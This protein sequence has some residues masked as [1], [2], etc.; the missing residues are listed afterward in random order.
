MLIN[1]SSLH[2]ETS[3]VAGWECILPEWPDIHINHERQK[4]LLNFFQYYANMDKLKNHVLC[5][6][7][8]TLIK[9]KKFFRIF[10]SSN[11]ISEVQRSK[12]KTF[13]QR[14][15]SNFVKHN[16]LAIQDPFELSFNLT[17]KITGSTLVDFCE[18][19]DQSAEILINNTW[20]CV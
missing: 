9:K 14:I 15:C 19:C 18:L 10:S 20:K 6:F 1:R 2:C 17:K 12:F 5:T 11:K 3:S 13:H 7:T 8:G 4:L 16:G